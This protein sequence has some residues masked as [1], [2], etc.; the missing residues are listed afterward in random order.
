MTPEQLYEAAGILIG[1][2]TQENTLQLPDSGVGEV[3]VTTSYNG[4]G[5]VCSCSLKPGYSW[6]TSGE[7]APIVRLYR[8]LGVAL[9]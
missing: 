4:P 7:T 3:E 1:E 8:G 5:G 9:V 2:P 6:A